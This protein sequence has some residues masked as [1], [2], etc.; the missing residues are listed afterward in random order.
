MIVFCGENDFLSFE[1]AKLHATKLASEMGGEVV[2]IAADEI[3]D[4]EPIRQQVSTSN[5]FGD[6]AVVLAKRLLTKKNLAAS[7]LADQVLMEAQNLV[8]WEDGKLDSRTSA[9]KQLKPFLKQFDPLPKY[10]FSEWTRSR[11]KQVYELNI[12]PKQAEFIARRAQE[13]LWIIDNE[14]R[15]LSS[16]KQPISDQFLATVVSDFSEEPIWNLLDNLT[17]KAKSLPLLIKQLKQGADPHYLLAMLERELRLVSSVKYS[18]EHNLP[19]KL[20]PFV[21]EKT[22]AKTNQFS[23]ERLKKAYLSLLKWDT[24]IKSGEAYPNLA[25]V[26][27]LWQI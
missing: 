26:L 17:N 16:A 2:S 15:K 7:L 27:S 10:K 24:A 23:W 21:L 13:N 4:L 25:V 9:A 12:S 3:Y 6:R 11:A 8:L 20:H 1:E 18:S 19:V 22:M 5:L 14:L